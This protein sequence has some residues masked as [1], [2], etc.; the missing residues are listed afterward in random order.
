MDLEKR[1][2]GSEGCHKQPFFNPY[3]R[4]CI[5]YLVIYD[6]HQKGGKMKIILTG[7]TGCL[8]PVVVK[9][10]ED[11]GLKTSSQLDAVMSESVDVIILAPNEI[12][13]AAK[14]KPETSFHVTYADM[15]KGRRLENM[16]KA[17]MTEEAFRRADRNESK[18][19]E[20]FSRWMCS[21][22]LEDSIYPSNVTA[23]AIIPME[24]T[25]MMDIV[26]ALREEKRVYDKCRE[27]VM[28]CIE[29]GTIKSRLPGTAVLVKI[30]DNGKPYESDCPVEVFTDHI[31]SGDEGMA[32]LMWAYLNAGCDN[33][34]TVK[35]P[36]KMVAARKKRNNR[37]LMR[38]M[39]STEDNR[40][41]QLS[42]TFMA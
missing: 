5:F 17:G 32:S 36:D 35:T 18:V 1:I 6:S 8:C 2:N 24:E 38:G 10:L 40:Y 42:L 19:F 3:S 16:K 9:G 22:Y 7:K 4:N 15:G 25:C 30:G 37:F 12:T 39:A 11:S 34:P 21:P 23:G 20:S 31:L 26:S 14:L 27:I 33:E 41:E 28:R 29:A 13:K